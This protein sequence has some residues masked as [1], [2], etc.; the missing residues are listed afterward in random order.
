ML[1]S[2]DPAPVRA[3]GNVRPNRVLGG[4]RRIVM[5]TQAHPHP[6]P[7]TEPHDSVLEHRID[8]VGWGLFLILVG[9]LWLMPHGW[10]PEGTWLVGTGVLLLG[11]NAVRR[12]YGLPVHRLGVVL[13]LLALVA[14]LAA[15]ANVSAPLV[16]AFL[17]VAGAWIVLKPLFARPA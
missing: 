11:L 10:V 4:R 14:G 8:D 7:S 15:M 3:P 5:S 12:F 1:V 9:A 13:G 17:I 6:F 2:F 16:P